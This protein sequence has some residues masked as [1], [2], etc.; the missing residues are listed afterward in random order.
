MYP[1]SIPLAET[2]KRKSLFL[3]GPRQT[4][5]STLLRT[6]FPEALYVDLLESNT[7]REL[8]AFP[9]TLRQRVR[10]R[11]K[12]LIV[13]EIQ[14]LPPLLDEVQLLLDRNRDLR[15]VLTGSSARKLRRGH[16]NLLGG[17]ALFLVL[18]P[19]I[20]AELGFERVLDR[21][22][23]GGLPSV[24]DSP[25]PEQDLGAYVGSYLKEEIL[26][27]GLTRSIGNFSRFLEMA[28]HLNGR[29]VNFT[30]VGNDAQVPPRTVRDYFQVLEDTL[31]GRM[32]PAFQGTSRRKAA[33]TA[34]FF[35]FDLGVARVLRRGGL[36]QARSP[37]F[38]EALE[39]LLFQEIRA[40]LD[41]HLS[42]AALTYW[43]SLSQFEVDFLIDG[44]V[45]IEVKAT[46]RVAPADLKG[47]KA[48]SE[49]LAL[50][51]KIV[52]CTEDAPREVDGIEIV[53]YDLFLRRLWQGEILG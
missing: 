7:F 37:A 28:S 46:G 15:I 8:S 9:E 51:R 5:K 44:R 25:A 50:E 53:P 24:L 45:A 36:I 41:Y 47:L 52:V 35:F 30:K 20:S 18:H 29:Q 2:V 33:A 17:R 14:K 6:L 21:M 10:P 27:E 11:E 22:N 1:R 42:S 12:M 4:G 40:C 39:H 31:V 19:L 16:A 38:G 26:A 34:K 48:L 13:D 23:F 32:L 3:L 49:D 43:R